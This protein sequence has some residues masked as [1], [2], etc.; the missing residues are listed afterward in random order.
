M[1]YYHWRKALT[2]QKF[3]YAGRVDELE[4]ENCR[5]RRADSQ[6]VLDKLISREAKRDERAD[7]NGMG[8]FPE[9]GKD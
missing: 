2:E 5:L 1:S 4:I 7:R 6:L 8:D 3:D 9:N